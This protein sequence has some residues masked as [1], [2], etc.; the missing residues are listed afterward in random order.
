[1]TCMR[2]AVHH[3]PAA[4][5]AKST[6]TS[7]SRTR[8][9]AKAGARLPR[10]RRSWALTI[11]CS[12]GPGELGRREPG[13]ALVLDPERV[14]PGALRLGN[15]EIRRDRMARALDQHRF[16]RRDAERDNVLDLEVDRFADSDTVPQAVV[17]DLDGC[18][19]DAED[20]AH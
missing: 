7:P 18:P 3:Q 13:L 15:R 10:G 1:M 12:G 17:D 5:S 20:V 9:A 16:T 2:Y 4:A 11:T 6:A 8:T 19:L 14:D